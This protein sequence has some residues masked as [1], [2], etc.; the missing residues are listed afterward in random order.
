MR[1]QDEGPDDKRGSEVGP[2]G[3]VVIP[4]HVP[5]EWQKQ[6]GGRRPTRSLA[7]RPAEPASRPTAMIRLLVWLVAVTVAAVAVMWPAAHAPLP[8]AVAAFVT[9][10]GAAVVAFARWVM[11]TGAGS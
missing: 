8:A 4:D 5:D 9:L 2:H 1:T 7:S 10:G 11:R 6:Y 3:R